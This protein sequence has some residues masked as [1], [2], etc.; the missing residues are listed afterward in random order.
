MRAMLSGRGLHVAGSPVLRRVA[1]AVDR[2]EISALAPCIER[3]TNAL[4]QHKGQ[5]IAAPQV[6]ESVRLFLIS[7]G[8]VRPPVAI[9]NP[10]LLKRSRSQSI[11]WESCLSVPDYAALVARADRIEVEYLNM[12]G[13]TQHGVL[14]GNRARVFQ[15]EMDHLDGILYTA[16]CIPSSIS[17]VDEL[18]SQSR[19]ATIESETLREVGRGGC[20]DGERSE[21]MRR[22]DE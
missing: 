10:Q 3:M 20:S 19:R 6:G 13:V 7:R 14:S 11:D 21:R 9:I 22:P 18:R 12:E 4:R 15:H 5:G 17:H 16:R 2:A 1:R 8:D